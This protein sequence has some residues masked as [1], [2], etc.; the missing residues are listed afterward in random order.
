MKD[1]MMIDP[2][3]RHEE[4]TEQITEQR[5]PEREKV[6]EPVAVRQTEFQNHNGDDDRQNAVAERFQSVFIHCRSPFSFFYPA[7]T[8]E[9]GIENSGT[10]DTYL[11]VLGTFY[12][13]IDD[14]AAELDRFYA[15]HDHKNYVIRIH[16]LKSSAMII[17]AGDIAG[18]A[19]LLENAAKN[20]DEG[21]L[22]ANHEGFIA[23]LSDIKRALSG[24][25]A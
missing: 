22:A 20:E 17:G 15:D 1:Q 5:R 12:S 24:A 16:A 6:P 18:K 10:P 11:S 21:Y 23:A 19:Q 9:K 25:F 4:I 14:K 3:D 7:K 8:K 13:T 2:I